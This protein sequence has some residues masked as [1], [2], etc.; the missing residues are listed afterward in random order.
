MR[1][2]VNL[3]LHTNIGSPY[4]ALGTPKEWV[5]A[6]SDLGMDSFAITEH[7]NMNSLA[8][9]VLSVQEI[10]KTKKF[11]PIYGVEFFFI[12]DIKEFVLNRSKI[13]DKNTPE[14]EKIILRKDIRRKYHLVVWAMNPVG[15]KNLYQLVSASYK[16]PY[17]YYK[18][19]IDFNLLKKYSEGLAGSSACMSGVI[20]GL[21]SHLVENLFAA[22]QDI[23]GSVDKANKIFKSI[24]RG[25][26]Y[27]EVQWNAYPRQHAQNK[28]VIDSALRC[29]IPLISTADSHFI[30]KEDWKSREFYFAMK[31][32]RGEDNDEKDYGFSDDVNELMMDL[33]LKNGDGMWAAYKEYSSKVGMTYDDAIIEESISNTRHVANTLEEF[34][35]DQTTKMPNFI[36]DQY[37][38]DPITTIKNLCTEALVKFGKDDEQYHSRLQM[39][40][41]LIEHRKFARYF[42]TMREIV[43]EADAVMQV[44]PARG[45]A[46][47]SLVSYLLGITQVDPIKFD[48]SFSRFLTFDAI[49]Y[50]DI[51]FDCADPLSLKESLIKKWGEEKI[52]FVSNWNMM[53]FKNLV[54][55]IA[56]FYKIAFAE[57]NEMTK[58]AI[59]ET[60]AGLMAENPEIQK[61]Y[62]PKLDEILKYSES[63]RLY[64]DRYPFLLE[65]VKTLIGQVRDVSTHAGGVIIGDNLKEDMPL[66]QKGGKYQ[67]PWPEG[68]SKRLLEPMGFIKFDVLGIATLQ[69]ISKTIEKILSRTQESVTFQDVKEF[70]KKT[71]HPDV[72]NFNDQKVYDHVFHKGNWVGVFQFSQEGVQ[73]FCKKFHPTSLVD[74]SVLTSIYRPG[75][76][77]AGVDQ[78]YVEAKKTGSKVQDFGCSGY[79]KVTQETNGFIIFQE[80]I[81]SLVSLMGEG[82]SE[83]DGQKVRKLLTKKKGGDKEKLQPYVE[84]LYS[85]CLA[86]GMKH[87]DI[88]KMWDT[89]SKFAAY[90]FNRSHAISYSIIT[91]QC[92]YLNTYYP[93]EWISSVLDVEFPLKKNEIVQTVMKSG[94]RIA[95]VV[96]GLSSNYWVVKK[97]T[98]YPPFWVIKGISED[99]GKFLHETSLSSLF[100][101]Y[102]LHK[103]K[104]K[105]LRTNVVTALV[106]CGS[107]DKMFKDKKYNK[108]AFVEFLEKNKKPIYSENHFEEFMEF[109]GKGIKEYNSLE[110][111][112]FLKESTDLFYADKFYPQEVVNQC[113]QMG[114]KLASELSGKI[115]DAEYIFFLDNITNFSGTYMLEIINEDGETKKLFS[116]DKSL[117]SLKPGA[118]YF[119]TIKRKNKTLMFTGCKDV[120]DFMI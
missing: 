85:G 22:P 32:L 115:V 18:P 104:K 71:L 57:T 87:E 107:F 19:R 39:E 96:Y 94:Y 37:K 26:W 53:G 30:R 31:F 45:S 23:I 14:E 54:K 1:D 112:L 119:A 90:G 58:T 21:Y 101:L 100:D 118:L 4:D 97:N 35:P 113:A 117:Y 5:Q 92:A 24:F 86:A 65:H 16:E 9:Y 28:V 89:V 61:T 95:P 13:E 70:Y 75:P 42:L 109:F 55:D 56:K 110:T 114:I 49:G 84:K 17:F 108:R 40:L 77:A 105:T 68:Q 82:I 76:L 25:N 6:A 83:D 29:G 60:N 47:G 12:K 103:T 36:M 120:K 48:L 33:S 27:N 11:K 74:L 93:E 80:Q 69:I 34:Y 111:G 67:T 72:I 73:E 79:A 63:A 8:E 2:F 44:G 20:G 116:K 102:N 43:Q 50:P 99:A 41:N 64:F 106:R 38:D 46:S 52:V 62:N 91:Y 66:I 81:S 7:G 88:D 51:D 59:E 98:A 78:M 3:H 15:L 10:N